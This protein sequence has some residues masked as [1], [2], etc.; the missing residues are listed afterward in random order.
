MFSMLKGNEESR[1][2]KEMTRDEV[3]IMLQS[4]KYYIAET[5]INRC[6]YCAG[7]SQTRIPD[8]ECEQ[9][10]NAGIRALDLAIEKIKEEM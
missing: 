3:I 9:C 4:L 10:I 2:V 6:T 8:E 7:C 5:P 1:R